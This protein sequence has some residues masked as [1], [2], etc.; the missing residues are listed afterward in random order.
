MAIPMCTTLGKNKE[1]GGLGV[2]DGDETFAG[3][4]IRIIFPAGIKSVPCNPSSGL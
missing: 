1:Q 3:H 2:Q 4:A